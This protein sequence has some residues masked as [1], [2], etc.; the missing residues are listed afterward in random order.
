MYLFNALNT[1]CWY[2][3]LYSMVIEVRE[4]RAVGGK[5]K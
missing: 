2:S 3:I 5:C 1:R 4:A